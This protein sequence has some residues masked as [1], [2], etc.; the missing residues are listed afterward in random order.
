M[1]L[2]PVSFEL[3]QGQ[4]IATGVGALLGAFSSSWLVIVWIKL[5][6]TTQR[7]GITQTAFEPV[8]PAAFCTDNCSSI[9][10]LSSTTTADVSAALGAAALPHCL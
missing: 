4:L 1:T 2:L 6:E 8:S 10:H 7:S 9:C 5:E 3:G